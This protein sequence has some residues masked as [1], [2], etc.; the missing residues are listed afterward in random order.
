MRSWTSRRR[1][2]E[3]GGAGRSR[4]PGASR[5]EERRHLLLP[6]IGP[7]GQGARWGSR[8]GSSYP[9]L[10]INSVDLA[11]WAEADSIFPRLTDP[12]LFIRAHR[13]GIEVYPWTINDPDQVRW[14]NR[15]GADGVVTD[16]P[17]RVRKGRRRSRHQRQSRRVPVLHPCHHFEGQD[18]T[19]C[20]C[21]LYPCKDPGFR[22]V[23]Q[24]EAGKEALELR[25]LHP[26]PQARS[27]PVLQGSPRR[28]HRGAEA[29]RSRWWLNGIWRPSGGTDLSR[30][31]SW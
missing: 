30:P 23:H 27:G 20:F 11:L 5:A 12:N 25:R 29:G 1:R 22:Q 14:L 9:P 15:L 4:R 28:H 19:F 17:C 18:C 8:Q 21:P 6:P 2:D 13:A 24:V 16:D 10:P 26:G 31:S 7:G 3:G